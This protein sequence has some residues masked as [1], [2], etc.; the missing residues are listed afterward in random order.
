MR[1]YPSR[2]QVLLLLAFLLFLA[3][4]V[5]AA[6]A[7]IFS[8]QSGGAILPGVYVAGADLGRLPTD[9][10]ARALEQ[11]FTARPSLFIREGG[12]EIRVEIAHLGVTHDVMASVRQA[13]AIGRQGT[14]WQR[15]KQLGQ[16]AV[17][18]YELPA[19]WRVD[20]ARFSQVLEQIAAQ[21]EREP[22]N[23]RLVFDQ[24][25]VRVTPR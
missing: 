14:F 15:V 6:S 20:E 18:G 2:R 11:R 13:A 21:L 23:A 19:V 9:A 16:T 22:R 24:G 25:T 1:M 12:R 5:A 10:A 17:A 8:Y 7:L 4:P 3:V